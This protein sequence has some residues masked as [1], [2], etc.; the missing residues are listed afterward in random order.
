MILISAVSRQPTLTA[1]IASYSCSVYLG[2]AQ[3]K[4]KHVICQSL[5]MSVQ[6]YYLIP[7]GTQLMLTH[8]TLDIEH[9]HLG[10]SQ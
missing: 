7:N 10:I 9:G 3:N 6:E 4:L 5:Q 8:V 2:T 1:T